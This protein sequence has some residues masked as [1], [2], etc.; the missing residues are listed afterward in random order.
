MVECWS[1]GVMDEW[2]LNPITLHCITPA[3]IFVIAQ[4][5]LPVTIPIR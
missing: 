5:M 3:F 2:K 4:P 1:Y